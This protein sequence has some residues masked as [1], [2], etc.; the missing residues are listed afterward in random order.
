MAENSLRDRQPSL[1]TGLIRPGRLE[2]SQRKIAPHRD[3]ISG[4]LVSSA[5]PIH[6]FRTVAPAFEPNSNR[7]RRKRL[8]RA[9]SCRFE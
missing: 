6:F 5:I 7:I 1:G 3:E 8:K 9:A 4:K 2:K